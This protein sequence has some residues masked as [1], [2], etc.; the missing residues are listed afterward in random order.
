MEEYIPRRSV[1]GIEGDQIPETPE[2]EGLSLGDYW[3]PVAAAAGDIGAQARSLSRMFNDK[4]G[5]TRA[6]RIDQLEQAN[7]Q[8]Y[9]D[10]T[11][12]S[13]SREG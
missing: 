4:I 9:A 11:R 5:N 10:Q 13:M 3:K 12:A 1:L 7:N 2:D 6:A 8:D